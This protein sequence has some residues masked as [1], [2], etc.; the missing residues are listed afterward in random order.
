MYETLA[1]KMFMALI[2][3]LADTIMT[4]DDSMTSEIMLATLTSLPNPK[5]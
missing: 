2:L 3:H 4:L 1:T 5:M